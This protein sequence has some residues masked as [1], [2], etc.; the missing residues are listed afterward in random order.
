MTSIS[1]DEF[2]GRTALV[3]GAAQGIGAAVARMLAD[4]G[5]RVVASDRSP[6]DLSVHLLDVTDADAVEK[7]VDLAE[8]EHGPL[9]ILV[10]VAGVLH[11]GPAL[12]TS[13]EDWQ[14]T[15]A[16]NTT[17][18]FHTCRSV[19]RRMADRGR[20][21]IVTVGSNAAGVPRMNMAAYAASK[22]ATTMFMRCL[23]LELAG[24]GVRCNLVS[25]G[26]TDTPMQR[27][28]WTDDESE[29]RVIEGDLAS[30]RAGIPL[31]RIATPEDI[32]E[33]VLFLAGDRARHVTMHDLYVDGGAT[34]RA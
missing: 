21:S 27:A 32:A 6:S 5:A 7:L 8:Q 15:F 31:R 17:G 10:N 3:T 29:R 13:D 33:A 23:G 1:T 25:P 34:L 19:G 4:R 16:V 12:S 22:A 11:A 28:L 9:D 24:S 20:G 14:H 30:Y 2:A 18:V 26:S